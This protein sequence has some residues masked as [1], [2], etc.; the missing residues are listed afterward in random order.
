MSLLSEAMDMSKSEI[1]RDIADLE[2]LRERLEA[3]NR[4]IFLWC[5][6]VTLLLA[7]LCCGLVFFIL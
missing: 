7:A 6:T 2:S 4:K 3:R 1:R 5:L